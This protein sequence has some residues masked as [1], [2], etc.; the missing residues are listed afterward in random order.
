MKRIIT[1]AI[2]V[3]VVIGGGVW[4]AKSRAA[5]P[6]EKTQFKI[7]KAETGTVK[8][9]VSATGTLQPWRVVDIKSKAGGRIDRLG[10]SAKKTVVDVGSM[11]K[12]GDII[13]EIDPTD[14]QLSFDQAQADI[15]SADAKIEGSKLTW[16]LQ[17]QQS[18][19]AVQTAKTSLDSALASLNSAKARQE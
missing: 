13:A 17:Q 1:I 18:K 3:L 14:T 9:T 15:N 12:K 11:V 6:T 7:A 4:I 5:A 19:L 2:T 8:K 16:E 10:D